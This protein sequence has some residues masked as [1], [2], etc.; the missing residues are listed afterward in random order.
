M[1]LRPKHLGRAGASHLLP[2]EQ[3]YPHYDYR[4]CWR[5]EILPGVTF[6]KERGKGHIW[7]LI[8]EQIEIQERN[9]NSHIQ[10][11]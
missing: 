7:S 6:G 4:K 3:A 5:H 10:V 2:T 9:V 1:T 8:V 11:P